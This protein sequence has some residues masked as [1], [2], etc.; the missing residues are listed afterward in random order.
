MVTNPV[1]RVVHPLLDLVPVPREA[2]VQVPRPTL[3]T[4]RNHQ[5]RKRLNQGR[6]LRLRVV[7]NK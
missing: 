6:Q 7:R 4:N 3:K 1:P 2:L 5:R